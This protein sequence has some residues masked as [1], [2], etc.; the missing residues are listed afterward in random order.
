MFFLPLP[1]QTF[2]VCPP[3]RRPLA[4]CRSPSPYWASIPIHGL[5]PCIRQFVSLSLNKMASLTFYLF[6]CSSVCH[7][8]DHRGQ[9]V[10]AAVVS[11]PSQTVY[12]GS[13]LYF[14][15]IDLQAIS[16]AHYWRTRNSGRFAP[17]FLAPAV[18]RE[19]CGPPSWGPL[20]LLLRALWA[21]GLGLWALG[22]VSLGWV[23]ACW[24]FAGTFQGGPLE[25]RRRHV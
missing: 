3:P 11:R 14:C 7:S 22:L 15:Y 2:S 25:K 13:L 20:G 1:R 10:D 23:C 4:Q 16:N 12:N 24:V 21:L 5:I 8:F 19:P 18:G 9:P 6:V 17:L